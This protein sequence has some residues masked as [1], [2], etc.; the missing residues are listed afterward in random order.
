[1]VNLKETYDLHW[2][3]KASPGHEDGVS[4]VSKSILHD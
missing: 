4:T 3:N 1:M 2:E